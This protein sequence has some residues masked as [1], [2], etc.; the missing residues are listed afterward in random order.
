M[1]SL[2]E[3]FED[4]RRI[5]D[6]LI[7]N[8]GELT[9]EILAEI[10]LNESNVREKIDSYHNL[11]VRMEY[12]TA[13][14]DAE[15]KRL[16]ALKRSKQNSVENLKGR[17]LWVM[18]SAGMRCADGN[19]CKAFV[20]DNAPSVQVEEGFL[21]E[22]ERM[23]ESLPLPPYVKLTASVDKKILKDILREEEVSGASLTSSQSVIFK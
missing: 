19:L 10:D 8:G 15:I 22:Y 7:E 2:N 17:L 12:G 14:I 5:E 13:E 9:D 23:A 18:N 20:R 3:L 16:Q 21:S 1:A 6:M 11:V 4:R